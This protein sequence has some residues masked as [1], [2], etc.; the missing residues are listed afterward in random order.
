MTF[1]G[2]DFE[3]PGDGYGFRTLGTDVSIRSRKGGHVH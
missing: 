1:A 3:S 2:S